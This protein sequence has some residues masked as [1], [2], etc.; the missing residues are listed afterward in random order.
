M[1]VASILTVS[2]KTESGRTVIVG[3]FSP[4][5]VTSVRLILAV[6]VHEVPSPALRA[7]ELIGQSEFAETSFPC[8]SVF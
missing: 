6:F 1:L 4:D 3:Y 7:Y 8:K 5:T 2:V